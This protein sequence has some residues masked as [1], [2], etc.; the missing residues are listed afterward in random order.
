MITQFVFPTHPFSP[1]SG[2][3]GVS[4][5]MAFVAW[6][7]ALQASHLSTATSRLSSNG[8]QSLLSQTGLIQ[9]MQRLP[10]SVAFL[11]RGRPA[12]NLA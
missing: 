12:P 8:S 9:L 11:H 6:L 10:S 1:W 5:V 4:C 3:K 2:S 7:L